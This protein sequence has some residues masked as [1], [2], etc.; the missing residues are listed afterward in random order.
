MSSLTGHKLV[1][2]KS[3]M[4]AFFDTFQFVSIGTNE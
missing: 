2:R 1:C 4:Y 3:N